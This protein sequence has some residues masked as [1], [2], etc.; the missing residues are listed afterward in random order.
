[1]TDQVTQSA[2]VEVAEKALRVR[3]ERLQGRNEP[4]WTETS[5]VLQEPRAERRTSKFVSATR[6]QQSLLTPVERRTLSWIAKRLPVWV[7]P[8]HLTALGF[9]AMLLAGLC[10]GFAR[11]NPL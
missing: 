9:A 7:Q 4:R 6:E 5:P 11:W 1:M 10:Y 3:W 2:G 8:D